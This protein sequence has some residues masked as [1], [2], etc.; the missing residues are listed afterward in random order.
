LK[1]HGRKA[2]LVGGGRVAA[3]KLET[4]LR[5]GA[6]VTVV[7]PEIRDDICLPGVE[8]RRR[9]FQPDD[10]DNVWFVVT[11]AIPEVNRQ[12]EATA[13]ARRIFVDAADDRLAATA[14][15]GAVTRRADILRA[16]WHAGGPDD[17]AGGDSLP[18]EEAKR[19]AIERFQRRYI[20]H[21]MEKT[22]GNISAA[23]RKAHLTRAAIH[24]ILKRLE[25]APDEGDTH[26]GGEEGH[27]TLPPPVDAG[28]RVRSHH[29]TS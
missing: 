28:I 18:Y 10:L 19:C 15:L 20:E 7:A 23:A 9:P 12:V 8:I 14:L 17:A 21:L 4:L 24:R 11:A 1:L 3:T 13:E 25:V 26:I 6:S 2:L 22:G 5:T 16:H 27:D 29:Y